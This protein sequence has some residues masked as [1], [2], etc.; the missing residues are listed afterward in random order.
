MK[1]SSSNLYA[2]NNMLDA[3]YKAEYCR[4]EWN[5]EYKKHKERLKIIM[6]KRSFNKIPLNKTLDVCTNPTA[7]VKFTSQGIQRQLDILMENTSLIRRLSTIHNRQF[8]PVI[9]L[10]T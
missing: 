4:N 9:P 6:A 8:R 10:L 3:I 1:Q 2:A 7:S 5:R